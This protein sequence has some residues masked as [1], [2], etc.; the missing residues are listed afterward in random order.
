VRT[1]DV[2]ITMGCGDTC[3]YFPGVSYRDWNV[4]D[5]A[6]QDLPAVRAIRDDI[7]TRVEALIAE[8]LPSTAA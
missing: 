1:S 8:L 7:K 2:V 4:A 6:G 3:P 5:P